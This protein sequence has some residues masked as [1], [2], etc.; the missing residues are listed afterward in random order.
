MKSFK[1]QPITLKGFAKVA[2][3]FYLVLALVLAYLFLFTENP[4]LTPDQFS[5]PVPTI[6]LDA[7]SAEMD[8]TDWDMLWDFCKG[9]DCEK[10]FH[11]CGDYDYFNACDMAQNSNK[12]KLL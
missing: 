6:D 9:R 2:G 10:K 11:P 3:V 12:E 5:R 4:K 8:A 7:E 1:L